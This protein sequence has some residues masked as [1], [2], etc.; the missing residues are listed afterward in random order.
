LPWPLRQYLIAPT[1]GA[2]GSSTLDREADGEKQIA[3]VQYPAPIR[4]RTIGGFALIVA[5]LFFVISAAELPKRSA[6]DARG[7]GAS[8]LRRPRDAPSWRARRRAPRLH[9]A[10]F[11]LVSTRLCA[12]L[13]HE[14]GEKQA[15]HPTTT[16]ETARN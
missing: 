3:A 14:A 9:R 15:T 16:Q 13:A 6:A 8:H 4:K 11:V 12:P 2:L 7:G 1:L 10:F 5:A